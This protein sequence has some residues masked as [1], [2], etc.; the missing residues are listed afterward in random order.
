MDGY[1]ISGYANELS[2]LAWTFPV[3]PQHAFSDACYNAIAGKPT[4]S[5]GNVNSFLDNDAAGLTALAKS[6]AGTRVFTAA[7][8][9]NAV[10]AAGDPMFAWEFEE[11]SYKTTGGDGF[12]AAT[13]MLGNASYASTLTH[14]KPWGFM[15]HPSGVETAVNTAVGIDDYGAATALGGV[16]VYH[17]HSSNGTVTIKLQDAATNTN[18]SFAD[19]SGA[20]SGSITAAVT[21]QSDMIALGTTATVRRYIRWQIVLGTATTCTFTCAFIRDV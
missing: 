6:G 2:E 19:L 8:G 1:D 10:P 11:T 12:L 7:M 9:T 21:P 3:T 17:L 14:R 20:T 15:V 13:V 18:P 5:A 4:I 16:F